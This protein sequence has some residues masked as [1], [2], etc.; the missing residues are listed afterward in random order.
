MIFKNFIPDHIYNGIFV[1]VK[2]AGID[3]T[4]LVAISS[5]VWSTAAG[6]VTLLFIATRFSPEVQGYY[7][8]FMTLVALN[9]FFELSLG[10]GILFFASHEWAHL[11]I[12]P[13]GRIQGDQDALDRLVNLGRFAMKW[14]AVSSSLFFLSISIGGYIFFQHSSGTQI[15]WRLP[16]LALCFFSAGDLLLLP[17]WV[18]LEGCNQVKEVYGYRLTRGVIHSLSLWLSIYLGADLAAPAIAVGLGVLWAIIVLIRRYA[19]FFSAFFKRSAERKSSLFISI[20]PMQW[21]LAVVEIGVFL[22]MNTFTPFLFKTRGPIE[23]GQMGMSMAL[24]NA[25]MM[26]S[27]M[28]CTAKAPQFGILV[29]K[30]DYSGLDDLSFRIGRTCVALYILGASVVYAGVYTLYS[31]KFSIAARLLPPGPT[32]IFLA[33]YPFL[34]A[35]C[36]LMAYLRAHKKEPL[37]IVWLTT[38]I[39]M[40]L[41][42]YF[43][44]GLWGP[45]GMAV[46]CFIL[47]AFFAFPASTYVFLHCRSD[48]HAPSAT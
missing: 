32:L 4:S 45:M 21:R 34:I 44:S 19:N 5:R 18:L 29:S 14:F 9:I 42:N 24:I 48:W 23:A 31:M 25:L 13:H 10:Q 27:L 1:R 40:L 8:T 20:F 15:S 39:S 2:N 6:P 33:A 38:G 43:V 41:M 12:D 47:L 37:F 26:V 35:I 16:W 22:T 11:K 7:Y 46:G 3:R 30:K 36:V 28:A 17:F